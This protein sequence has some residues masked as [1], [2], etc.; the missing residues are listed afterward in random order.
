MQ[1]RDYLKAQIEQLGK[2]LSQLLAKA[3]GLDG[4]VPESLLDEIAEA[5]KTQLDFDLLAA[6]K[7][8]HNDFK[9]ELSALDWAPTHLETMARTLQVL[10]KQAEPTSEPRNMLEKALL[11]LEVMEE[12]S[13]SISFQQLTLAQELKD[14]LA[15]ID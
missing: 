8:E 11:V 5:Y 15:K 7:Q 13:R 14:A 12:Q 2:V 6:L 9:A 1:Q 10:S 4:N 3:L